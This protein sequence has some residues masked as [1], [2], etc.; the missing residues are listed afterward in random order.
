MSAFT[1]P[2]PAPNTN[3]LQPANPPAARKGILIA[4]LLLGLL[5]TVNVAFYFLKK[6]DAAGAAPLQQMLSDKDQALAEL[7][8]KYAAAAAQMDS[9]KTANPAAEG[10]IEALQS[11]LERKRA[12]IEASIRLQGDLQAARQQIAELMAQKDAAV[13]EATQL[14]DKVVTLNRRVE[15][16]SGENEQLNYSIADSKAQ[17][18]REQAAKDKLLAD[19]KELERA[20]LDLQNNLNANMYLTVRDV[21]ASA[22]TVSK[23]GKETDTHFAKKAER[24]RIRFTVNAN[25]VVP[26]GE[27]TFHIKI[28]DPGGTTLYLDNQK[29]GTAQEKGGKEFRYSTVADCTYSQSETEASTTWEQEGQRLAKGTYTVEVFNRGRKVGDASFKVK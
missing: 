20:N 17:L 16:L 19:K 22:V 6:S 8:Q 5:T 9:I 13:L 18:D 4:L 26:S 2:P 7:N 25:P 11:E 24:V 23:K 28:T 12:D 14:K 29:S 1:P 3:P 21:Q 10:R 15:T 27:E